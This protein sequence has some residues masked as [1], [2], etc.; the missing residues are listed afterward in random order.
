M[1]KLRKWEPLYTGNLPL[2]FPPCSRFFESCPLMGD[3]NTSAFTSVGSNTQSLN[4]MVLDG[5]AYS[6]GFLNQI[7]QNSVL[8][9]FAADFPLVMSAFLSPP[10][11]S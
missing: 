9:E 3:A 7:H 4:G 10:S 1:L 8:L 11:S 6:F 2:N 5:D